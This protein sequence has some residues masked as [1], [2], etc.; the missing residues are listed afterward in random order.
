MEGITKAEKKIYDNHIKR[1]KITT[2][3]EKFVLLEI[4]KRDWY[5]YLI[6]LDIYEIKLVSGLVRVRCRTRNASYNFSVSHLGGDGWSC[7][8]EDEQKSYIRYN[9][10]RKME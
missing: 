10:I 4:L 2:E 1:L 8:D 3:G 5:R 9:L 7:D 6:L